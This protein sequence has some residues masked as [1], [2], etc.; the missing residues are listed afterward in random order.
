MTAGTPSNSNPSFPS[1]WRTN[2]TD[3]GHIKRT[4]VKLE[5]QHGENYGQTFVKGTLEFGRR[6]GAH[7]FSLFLSHC[8]FSPFIF[9]G[10]MPL[11]APT[12]LWKKPHFWVG[13]EEG[14]ICLS[15]SWVKKVGYKIFLG[16]RTWVPPRRRCQ[17]YFGI[18]TESGCFGPKKSPWVREGMESACNTYRAAT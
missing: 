8:F 12:Y 9:I 17:L 14:S 7:L 16:F 1:F 5:I 3:N 4:E 6:Q 18:W 2:G 10:L 13:R 15:R 11:I